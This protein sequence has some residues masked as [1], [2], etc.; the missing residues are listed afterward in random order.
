MRL[1]EDKRE[2]ETSHGSRRNNLSQQRDEG[3]DEC[4]K[5]A[6]SNIMF[7]ETGA[8]ESHPT[9]YFYIKLHTKYM[10]YFRKR[11]CKTLIKNDNDRSNTQ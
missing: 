7:S 3:F 10:R 6:P 9:V 4:D 8:P 2:K 1:L 11:R 5:T